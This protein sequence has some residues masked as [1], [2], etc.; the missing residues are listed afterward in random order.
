MRKP[1]QG[2]EW[3]GMFIMPRILHEKDGKIIQE[4]NPEIKN[5]FTHE[6]QE[7]SFAQPFLLKTTFN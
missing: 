7:I 6:V 5:S 1:V 2:E 3:I 4:L